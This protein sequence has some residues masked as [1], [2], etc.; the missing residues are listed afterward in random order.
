M[1]KS[2]EI[3]EMKRA[4]CIT[5]NE[6]ILIFKIRDS[7]W[8]IFLSMADFFTKSFENILSGDMERSFSFWKKVHGEFLIIL[9]GWKFVLNSLL[10]MKRVKNSKCLRYFFKIDWYELSSKWMC[11]PWVIMTNSKFERTEEKDYGVDFE[12]EFG[13]WKCGDV[14]EIERALRVGE[15]VINLCVFLFADEELIV[16]MRVEERVDGRGF[17][18]DVIEWPESDLVT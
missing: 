4:L 14:M 11:F 15:C 17:D 3:I 16:L 10:L 18:F 6:I 8:F 5:D 9:I 1:T 7:K 13:P 12:W 2:F